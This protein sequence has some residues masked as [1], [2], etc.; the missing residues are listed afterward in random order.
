MT[1]NTNEKV[2]TSEFGSDFASDNQK[3]SAKSHG[4]CIMNFEIDKG[5]E[6]LSCSMP[7]NVNEILNEPESSTKEALSVQDLNPNGNANV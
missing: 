6:I 3:S 4:V 7:I 5:G 1:S 2:I